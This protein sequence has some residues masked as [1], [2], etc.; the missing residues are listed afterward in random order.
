MI[1]R[2]KAIPAAKALM[3]AL[4]LPVLALG[5]AAQASAHDDL[6]WLRVEVSSEESGTNIKVRLPLSLMEVVIE[7]LGSGNILDGITHHHGEIDIRS[8]WTSIRDMEGDDFVTIETDGES[9][10]VWK[11]GYFLR[12]DVEEADT[13]TQVEVK[14][15]YELLD[16]LFESEGDFSFQDMVETL[17]G[18]LPLTLVKVDGP[19][20]TVRIWVE[21][22]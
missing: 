2:N 14:L 5:T 10:R 9:V 11:D 12:I 15:P 20:E 21:E 1:L 19:N 18:Q 4:A 13:G 3:V 16:Y 7:S 22:E 17:R 6:I 8:I